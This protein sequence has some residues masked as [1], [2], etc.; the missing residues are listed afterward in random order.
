M[1][2]PNKPLK[3]TDTNQLNR[4]FLRFIDKNGIELECEGDVPMVVKLFVKAVD[5]YLKSEWERGK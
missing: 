5:E 3:I 2:C 4:I 1:I